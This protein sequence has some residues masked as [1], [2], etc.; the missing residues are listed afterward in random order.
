MSTRPISECRN[1]VNDN[2]SETI[3]R[4]PQQICFAMLHDSRQIDRAVIMRSV[5]IMRASVEH[6]TLFCRLAKA[7]EGQIDALSLQLLM[8]YCLICVIVC[9]VHI[10]IYSYR[11]QQMDCRV[12]CRCRLHVLHNHRKSAHVRLSDVYL[13]TDHFDQ[14]VSWFMQYVRSTCLGARIWL[15]Y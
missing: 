3:F 14:H 6:T 8:R 7:T 5:L 1:V 4:I 2:R 15:N 11:A 9:F 10:Y 12:L 13:R